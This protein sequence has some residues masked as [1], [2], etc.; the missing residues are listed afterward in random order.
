VLDANL[1]SLLAKFEAESTKDDEEMQPGNRNRLA[2]FG[3]FIEFIRISLSDDVL[4]LQNTCN[5][6]IHQSTEKRFMC[7]LL[8]YLENELD[9][10]SKEC[11][12]NCL[13]KYR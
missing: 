2:I 6:K 5:I 7:C 9:V 3:Q 8:R 12:L 10:H 1:S 11:L 4:A 13:N